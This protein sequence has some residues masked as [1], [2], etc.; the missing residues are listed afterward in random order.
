M[1]NKI[2]S[3]LVAEKVRKWHIYDASDESFGR[4]ASKIAM[5][6]RGKNKVDF[7]HHVDAGDFVVVINT[8][9]VKYTKG[10][11]DGKIYYSYSGYMGGM[12]EISLKNQI[13]KDSREVIK[14]AVYGMLP[15]NKLRDQM[16]KRLHIYKD[17]KHPYG[18]KFD[19]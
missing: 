2:S 7:V 15:K 6:L 16:I 4:M 18:K 17:K 13:Q 11:G 3:K 1:T 5:I 9:N 12:S 19:N 14:S 10:K 8:D